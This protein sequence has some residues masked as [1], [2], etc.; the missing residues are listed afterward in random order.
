C[1]GREAAIPADRYCAYVA[2]VTGKR[3]RLV[4]CRQLPHSNQ[5]VCRT[6]QRTPGP[7]R[8]RNGGDCGA[9]ETQSTPLTPTAEIP[10]SQRA[11]RRAGDRPVLVEGNS[12]RA[13]K[14]GMASESV[15]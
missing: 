6:D 4:A 3:A 8:N 11:V 13:D 1:R 15:Q 14:C 9:P 5:P 7:R 10:N 12:N 2:D